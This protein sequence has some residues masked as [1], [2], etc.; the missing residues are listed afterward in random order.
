MYE[1]QINVAYPH[2]TDFHGGTT[3]RHLF[4]TDWMQDKDAAK[5]AQDALLL[6]FPGHAVT[7]S[8]RNAIRETVVL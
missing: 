8:R 7:V 5:R 1:Y 3:Y 6:A 4:R 2:G